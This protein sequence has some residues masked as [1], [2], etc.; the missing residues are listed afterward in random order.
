MP[1]PIRSWLAV[2]LLACSAP[3]QDAGD[4]S[5]PSSRPT[6]TVPT[7]DATQEPPASA[8]ASKPNDPRALDFLLRAATK[9]APQGEPRIA[10]ATI[11][12][13]AQ[14]NL[15]AHN[16]VD[17]G[18]H[19]FHRSGGWIRTKLR[20][21]TA[22]VEK[23]FDGTTYWLVSN[24]QVRQLRGREHEQDRNE[25]ASNVHFTENLLRLLSLRELS[26]EFSGLQLLEPE[27]DPARPGV[28]G[29]LASF[30]TLQPREP[31][32]VDV[33]L[34]FD[35]ETLD[36]RTV[37][38]TPASDAATVSD[39]SAAAPSAASDWFELTS[40]REVKGVR[41]PFRVTAWTKSREVPEYL[42]LI[43]SMSWNDG[44]QAADFAPPA[45]K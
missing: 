41:F 8:P 23:G 28:R 32:A 1:T 2:V 31:G 30:L 29:R 38:A 33:E 25:I 13:Q 37:R 36:L 4:E 7:N 42:V 21:T 3:A 14:T 26:R 27:G 18:E 12:F 10:D 15:K 16:E 11:A 40:W 45:S 24:G 5:T 9:R 6:S 43:R 39:A 34:R 22:V 19:R 20:T 17:D 44:L 35:P